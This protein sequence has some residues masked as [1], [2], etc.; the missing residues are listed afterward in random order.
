M[1]VG[2]R[3]AAATGDWTG[4]NRL[5]MMPTDDYR[6]SDSRATVTP[7]AHGNAVTIAYTWAE[8]GAPQE[9]LLLIGDGDAPDAVVAVWLDS[10]HQHPQWMTLHGA[11]DEAGVVRLDGSYAADAGWRIAIDP[12]DGGALRIGMDNVMPDTG[13]Y[14]VVEIAYARTA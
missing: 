11:I 13:A 2:E 7:A 9:G 5:R 4:T 8:D 10:W 3:L 1:R 6:A 14:P 12:G